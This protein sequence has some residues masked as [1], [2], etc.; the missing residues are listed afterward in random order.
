MLCDVN[1]VQ[2]VNT[3]GKSPS[4]NSASSGSSSTSTENVVSTFESLLGF[5]LKVRNALMHDLLVF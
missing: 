2:A 1:F 3:W 4:K 5:K